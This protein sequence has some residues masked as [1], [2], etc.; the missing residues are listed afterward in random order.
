MSA[1]ESERRLKPPELIVAPQ[2]E[3][4][5]VAARRFVAAVGE[6]IGQRG[7]CAVSLS[8]GATPAALYRV[9]LR[10]EYATR[11]D[12]KRIDF[13]WG[14]ER[15]VP[16]THPRSNYRVA[17]EILL[18]KID[19]QPSQVHRIPGELS[20]PE[21]AALHY[22]DEL[23]AYF[24]GTA[25]KEPPRFDLV[26]LGVGGDG[27]TASLFPYGRSL[28]ETERRVV[29]APRVE[30]VTRVTFTL[31]LLNAARQVHFLAVGEEKSSAVFHIM[32]EKGEPEAWP[33]RLVQ[34]GDGRA[35]L[36]VDTAAASLLKPEKRRPVEDA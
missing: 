15:C 23:S 12:W 25:G 11:I 21:Q 6:A 28:K 18:S 32:E 7:A 35:F 10:D 33:A 9:L 22:E 13:F 34:P 8:G 14:D 27:H 26:L 16:P 2:P 30:D 19:I 4:F 24:G 1:G 20:D 5:E 3:I 29:T 36:F 17:H 31:P